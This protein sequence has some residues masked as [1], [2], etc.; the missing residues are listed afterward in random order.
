VLHLWEFSIYDGCICLLL[1]P[2]ESVHLHNVF[3]YFKFYIYKVL[4]DFMCVY[5]LICIQF[6]FVFTWHSLVGRWGCYNMVS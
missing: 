2:Y 5:D 4:Q 1:F 6:N 3:F